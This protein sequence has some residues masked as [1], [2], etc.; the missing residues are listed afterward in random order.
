MKTVGRKSARRASRRPQP[1]SK[2]A[3]GTGKL[4]LD[5]LAMKEGEWWVAQ[6]LQYDLT[7]QAK[8]LPELR[9]AFEYALVGHIITSL[10]NNLEPF[11]SLPAAP[12]E[13]WDAW[14]KALPV[15]IEAPPAFRIPRHIPME[16]IPR[17]EQFRVA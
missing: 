16:L 8:T 17:Q 10:E 13:Y 9:Y 14:Q 5:V 1:R 4:R 3:R 7:A 12:K 2:R 15:D 6:C 11:D